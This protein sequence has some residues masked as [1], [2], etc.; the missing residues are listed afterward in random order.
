MSVTGKVIAVTGGASGM[1][2][3]LA[4][5]LA[6]RGAKIFKNVDAAVQQ[7]QAV[8]E[9]NDHVLGCEVD[10]TKPETITSWLDST[11]QKFGRLD[12]A[13]NVAGICIGGDES[14]KP[15]HENESEGHHQTL[16]VNLYGL[17]NC[18]RGELSRMQA[19][20]SIVN[21]ASVAGVRPG[22]PGKAGYTTSKFGAIG[23]TKHLAVEYGPRGIRLNVV[24]PG[25]IDTP[26]MAAF[27]KGSAETA[28]GLPRT[29]PLG[30]LGKPEEVANVIAFL[31]SD[32]A[33]YVTGSVYH[34][35]GGLAA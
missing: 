29:T 19:G 15:W 30:R 4:Q 9:S 17:E 2:L 21:V 32:D 20:A 33:S 13:A 34:V 26:M 8:A 1:G 10:I 22:P 11:V 31:L 5:V 6:R 35:D 27:R 18:L 28:T 12:G 25:G 7:V 14:S 23:L 3:A 24:A 16:A